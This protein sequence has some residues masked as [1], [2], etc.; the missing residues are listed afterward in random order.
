MKLNCEGEHWI[1]NVRS[2]LLFNK[3]LSFSLRDIDDL[4]LSELFWVY[5]EMLMR[6]R[7]EEAYYKDEEHKKKLGG[8]K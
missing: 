2:S 1:H 3:K 6:D 4:C 7:F 5:N 8:G